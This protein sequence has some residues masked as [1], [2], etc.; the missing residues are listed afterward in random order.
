MKLLL[1]VPAGEYIAAEMLAY[2]GRPTSSIYA[3]MK[4]LEERWLQMGAFPHL[5]KVFGFHEGASGELKAFQREQFTRTST[6]EG[7]RLFREK[8]RAADPHG[9]FLT[10]HA[11]W[12]LDE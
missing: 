1:P 7:R 9:I 8:Q 11:S 3:A 4:E 2:T 12:F 5:S 10:P 6:A